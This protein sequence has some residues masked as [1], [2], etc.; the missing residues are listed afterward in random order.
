MNILSLTNEFE[1]EMY[2]GAGTAVT[3]ML[4]MLDRQGVKQ[5]VVVPRSDWSTSRWILKGQQL[6]MLG[7]PR[8]AR[9]FGRLGMINIDTVLSEFPELKQPYDLIHIHA[10]NFTPL[11]YTL[12]NARLPILYSVYSFMR[13]ELGESADADLQAQFRIQDDLLLRSQKIHLLSQSEKHYFASR[14]SQSLSKAEVLPLGISHPRQSWHKGNSNRFLYAGRLVEYKGIEDLIKAVFLAKQ[15]GRQVYLD[16]MGRGDDYYE[17]HL[18]VLVRTLKLGHNIRFLGWKKAG[19]EVTQSM[20]GALALVVPSWRE[21][22]GLT[23]LEGMAAG[24]PLIVSWVDG[25]AELA[26]SS[27]ALTFEAG[28]VQKL[29]QAL[30]TALEKP[31]LLPMLAQKAR[32]RALSF[33][34]GNL[35][36]RY[37]HAYRQVIQLKR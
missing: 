22:F 20:V 12:A 34:W 18:Q 5:T 19:A 4:Y 24:V 6:R 26:D 11:A 33:E 8:N 14:Y 35:A 31:D 21:A 32:A 30:G 17:Q 27:C 9:Y 25:L 3:G 36:P 23:A 2:G 16:I 37:L 1:E 15:G 7:I 28:N 29:A 10:I 13:R